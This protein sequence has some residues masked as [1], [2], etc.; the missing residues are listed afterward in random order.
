MLV[1]SVDGG[2]SNQN[3]VVMKCCR[4]TGYRSPWQR[5]SWQVDLQVSVILRFF[6]MDDTEECFSLSLLL[7]PAVLQCIMGQKRDFNVCLVATFL[8][9]YDKM[10]IKAG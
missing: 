10:C 2:I 8:M 1:L 4:R 5:T 6:F 9:Q 3:M 7:L